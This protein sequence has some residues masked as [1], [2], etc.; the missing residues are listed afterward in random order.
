[1]PLLDHFHPPL[2]HHRQWRSF[3]TGWAENLTADLNKWLPQGYFAE[4]T[5]TYGIEIDVATFTESNSP[6]SPRVLREATIPYLARKIDKDTPLEWQV[7]PPNHTIPFEPSSEVVEVLIYDGRAGPDLVGAIELVSPA[8]K[9]RPAERST[10]VSKCETYL[11]LGVGL[12]IVD[13]VTTRKSNLHNELMQRLD[14]PSEI[15]LAA[16]LY[17]V[18]YRIVTRDSQSALDCWPEKLTLGV[19]LPILPLW[20][21]GDICIP[22]NLD[23]TYD[24]TCM[25]HRITT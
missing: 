18:A 16:D 19:K 10:F 1:M 20:L 13:I 4:P 24:E 22:V 7:P 3:H 2:S 23:A 15:H 17:T 12:I 5:A 8:N 14:A 25:R 9:D 11:S 6:D 21:K